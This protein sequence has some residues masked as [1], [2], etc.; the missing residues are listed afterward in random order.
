MH[1][2]DGPGAT[3]DNKFTDGDPVGG[4]PATMVTDDWLNDVQESLMA[5]LSAAG[6]PPTK[7]RAADLLDSVRGRLINVR[8]FAAA[9]TFVYTPSAGTTRI[10]VE[11]CGAGGA[12]AG[13]PATTAGNGSLGSAGGAGAY[14]QS[15]ITSGFAGVSIVVGAGGTGV[16]GSAGNPGGSSSFGGLISCPGGKGGATAGPSPGSFFAV[17]GNSNAPSGGNIKNSVGQAADISVCFSPSSSQAGRGGAT[18]FG[19]GA[20]TA[21]ANVAGSAATS[22]GSGGGGTAQAASGAALAGGAGAPGIVVV[23][24]YA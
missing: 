9:G 24:E 20:Q 12:G 6:V 15:F 13:A 7:G 1:R 3:V 10:I 11:C 17:A 8:V 21:G 22:P 2:I 5:V 4:V 19:P 23:W 18:L 14:A 16:S